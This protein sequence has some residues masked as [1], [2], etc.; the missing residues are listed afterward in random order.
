MLNKAILIHKREEY[1]LSHR[2][3]NGGQHEVDKENKP[4]HLQGMEERIE[5]IFLPKRI[6][7]VRPATGAFDIHVLVRK[8]CLNKNFMGGLRYVFTLFW[9]LNAYLPPA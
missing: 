8:I 5:K 1:F 7:F 3:D 2:M 6:P 4:A 9:Y